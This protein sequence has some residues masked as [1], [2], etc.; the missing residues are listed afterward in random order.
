M[1]D[2]NGGEQFVFDDLSKADVKKTFEEYL[3][4]YTPDPQA[5]YTMLAYIEKKIGGLVI[6]EVQMYFNRIDLLFD[7]Y[8]DQLGGQKFKC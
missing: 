6:V 4:I 2:N 7:Y 8:I 3:T 5:K 1:D